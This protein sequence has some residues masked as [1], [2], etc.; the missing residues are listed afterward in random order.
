MLKKV[1][2]EAVVHPTLPASL[3]IA[4]ESKW[5]PETVVAQ[6]M[7]DRH[8]VTVPQVLIHWSHKPIDEATWEDKEF[9]AA[10]FP[11]FSLEDKTD[12]H[13]AGNDSAQDRNKG[14]P[15]IWRV[16]ERRNKKK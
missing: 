13:G 15:V 2:G 1:V 5:E 12:S 14:K 6:R 3:E 11:N 9:V 10:Q 7:I 8:G 16:Y 4:E